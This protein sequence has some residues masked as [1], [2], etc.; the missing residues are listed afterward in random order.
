[1]GAK[2]IRMTTLREVSADAT[3]R[4]NTLRALFSKGS[5]TDRRREPRKEVKHMVAYYWNGEN[6][7]PHTVRDVTRQGL[8]LV[9]DHRWWIG[10]VLLMTLQDTRS[11]D[12]TANRSIAVQ[13]KV[14]RYGADGIGLQLLPPAKN[15]IWSWSNDEPRVADQKSLLQFVSA[16]A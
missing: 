2:R 1:M 4:M 16:A 5:G 3:I 12:Q 8:Y 7:V 9:T 13:A 10:S 6:P 11:K 14:V 15:K